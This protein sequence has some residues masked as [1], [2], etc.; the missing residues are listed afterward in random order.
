VRLN[1]F[2]AIR[3]S[4][5]NHTSKNH[6]SSIPSLS[7]GLLPLL[8][9]LLAMNCCL[10]PRRVAENHS[11]QLLTPFPKMLTLRAR[12]ML[13]SSRVTELVSKVSKRDSST[14]DWSVFIAEMLA[15]VRGV[16]RVEPLERPLPPCTS[17]PAFFSPPTA[18]MFLRHDPHDPAVHR[19]YHGSLRVCFG[20]VALN[21][22]PHRS[23]TLQMLFYRFFAPE[24]REALCNTLL[25]PPFASFPP[26]FTAP[27]HC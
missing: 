27:Y 25:H 5:M 8:L 2:L 16:T 26:K 22:K 12:C 20:N 19:L 7:F 3:L 14:V 15:T 17:P 6:T 4:L 13:L 21:L 9:H 11:H 18:W 1:A 24:V 23:P 10:L